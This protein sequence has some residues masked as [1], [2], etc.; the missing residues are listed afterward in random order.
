[1]AGANPEHDPGG[2]AGRGPGFGVGGYRLDVTNP[3]HYLVLWGLTLLLLLALAAP[4]PW[5][6]VLFAAGVAF[7]TAVFITGR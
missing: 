3:I 2:G 1:M 4:L 5:L 7:G 6:A